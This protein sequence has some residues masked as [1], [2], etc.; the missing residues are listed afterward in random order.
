LWWLDPV[1]KQTYFFYFLTHTHQS[2][3]LAEEI[4]PQDVF[5][6]K[7]CLGFIEEMYIKISN[8]S[9]NTQLSEALPGASRDLLS[10]AQNLA[11]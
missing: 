3:E 9:T 8:V 4:I 7:D 1:H 6:Q 2:P 5:V 11:K 10:A